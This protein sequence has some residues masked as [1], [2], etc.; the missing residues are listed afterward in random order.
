MLLG[1]MHRWGV[2]VWHGAAVVALTAWGLELFLGSPGLPI[3]LALAGV[4]LLAVGAAAFLSYREMDAQQAEL[5]RCLEGLCRDD[6]EQLAEEAEGA[7]ARP[8]TVNH[9]WQGLLL[10]L[11]GCLF[12]IVR[13]ARDAEHGRAGAEVRTRRTMAERDQFRELLAASLDPILV[14]DPYDAITF[15]NPAAERIFGLQLQDDTYGSA[16]EKLAAE[17]FRAVLADTRRRNSAQGRTATLTTTDATGREWDFRV[18][19]R[20]LPATT[21]SG[22]GRSAQSIVATF[23]DIGAQK[24]LQ[25]RN[26]EFVSS[27][28]H[29]MKTPLAGINAYVELLADGDAEDEATRAEFLG[30]IKSQAERLQRLVENLLNLARIEAGVVKVNK[31]A[32]SLNE[33]LQEAYDVLAPTAEMKNIRLECDLS[34]MYLGVFADH[35][36]LLQAAINLGSNAVKYTPPGGRVTIRSSLAD[37]EVTFE[38]SDTGVGLSEEDR[39]KVFEKFYRVKK[40][41]TMAPGTGLGLSLVKHIVEDVHSG[42]IEVQSELGHGSTFRVIL[43]NEQTKH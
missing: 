32:Q 29:E 26:A 13:R 31:R 34:S 36:T 22:E 15:A 4:T 3:Q 11:R 20:A 25:K 30:V 21:P 23:S 17:A 18:N 41:S 6:L 38:V 40:D 16:T 35:D 43:P 2:S 5:R 14:I 28:S 33:V 27:V 9:E 39:L 8:L 37:S 12:D 7:V 24:A 1:S 19:C 10:R 42:R